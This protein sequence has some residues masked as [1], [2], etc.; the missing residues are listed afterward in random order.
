MSSPTKGQEY[1]IAYDP[2]R[3]SDVRKI[4]NQPTNP[5]S[6]PQK[7]IT[8][9]YLIKQ[10]LRVFTQTIIS[11]RL[12]KP[13]PTETVIYSDDSTHLNLQVECLFHVDKE[14]EALWKEDKIVTK[15][16]FNA[17][18]ARLDIF[19]EQGEGS[20]PETVLLERWN[21]QYIYC[22]PR[23]Q[24]NCP[25]TI[26]NKTTAI[27]LRS[28]CSLLRV[29]PMEKL[30]QLIRHRQTTFRLK[31]SLYPPEG[32][33]LQYCPTE[34]DK[35]EFNFSSCYPSSCSSTQSVEWT[36]T[37]KE[38]EF[39]SIVTKAGTLHM[40]VEY[41]DNLSPY[42]FAAIPI[43]KFAINDYVDVD[44]SPNITTKKT[45]DTPPRRPTS[46]PI[47][48][49]TYPAETHQTPPMS[50]TPPNHHSSAPPQYG[51]RPR[52][53]TSTSPPHTFH[54]Q[55]S[56]SSPFSDLYNQPLSQHFTSPPYNQPLSP[57]FASAPT[58]NPYQDG[59][60][61]SPYGGSP[62]T[63]SPYDQDRNWSSPYGGS[64]P[65]RNLHRE[66]SWTS[67]ATKNPNHWGSPPS[68]QHHNER[69]WSP[70]YE[71]TPPSHNPYHG[72]D[73]AY[74]LSPPSHNPY[75]ERNGP[76][77]TPPS[78]SPYGTP[79]TQNPRKDRRSGPP[80]H[81][82]RYKSK[83][84]SAIDPR[85]IKPHRANTCPSFPKANFFQPKERVGGRVPGKPERYTSKLS[86]A[87]SDFT[88]VPEGKDMAMDGKSSSNKSPY[89]YTSPPSSG[90]SPSSHGFCFASPPFSTPKT[91]PF[92]DQRP[93]KKPESLELKFEKHKDFGTEKAPSSL[94]TLLS[95]DPSSHSLL[96]C[97]P[98]F[99]S[100]AFEMYG[101]EFDD[102]VLDDPIASTSS[103]KGSENVQNSVEFGLLGES[104]SD[105][106]EPSSLCED[107]SRLSIGGGAFVSDE[108]A[109]SHYEVMSNS[110]FNKFHG[111]KQVGDFVLMCSNPP[112]LSLFEKKSVMISELAELQEF[113][114]SEKTK[115]EGLSK[116]SS[117]DNNMW[118]DQTLD[119]SQ[120]MMGY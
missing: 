67:P 45:R 116:H 55:R 37:P 72:R 2:T 68:P 112:S 83:P 27:M 74:S 32:P 53:K 88:V 6:R 61:A 9:Q 58:T 104:A 26:N 93:S 57:H 85:R 30:V 62:T 36:D 17:I 76:Y 117:F 66:R 13:G 41:L 18:H 97:S 25:D 107:L 96:S 51:H 120:A 11:A 95:D 54:R 23:D 87:L 12:P 99:S 92:N 16:G 8:L 4:Q 29:L 42:K 34:E 39:R 56:G 33:K 22:A 24:R 89:H 100:G 82:P 70:P 115:F 52:S 109:D 108:H 31:Y 86:S 10:T 5:N 21:L 59:N 84:F 101:S 94:G 69:D 46:P 80:T 71:A 64:P 73:R 3:T 65:S 110:L 50:V 14:L 47:P 118:S 78:H 43:K 114:D 119:L 40:N 28:L 75:Q 81:N 1:Q 113:W 105:F 19:A 90:T 63:Q 38:F 49:S 77:D 60:W 35:R 15:Q 106:A 103:F 98:P 91:F 111:G 79:E 102:N 20:S 44:Y 7:K 48:V